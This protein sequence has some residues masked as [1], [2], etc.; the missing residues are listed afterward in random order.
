MRFFE[1][2]QFNIGKKQ[3]IHSWLKGKSFDGNKMSLKNN[4]LYIFLLNKEKRDISEKK[5]KKDKKNETFYT[6]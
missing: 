2:L 5:K 1:Y 4:F 6:K 3:S